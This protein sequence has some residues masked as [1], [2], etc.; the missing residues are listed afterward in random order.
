M[1]ATREANA[2]ALSRLEICTNR[3]TKIWRT[4]EVQ[5]L[6]PWC[7]ARCRLFC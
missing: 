6:A 5:I 1:H 3:E 2:A 4:D 7:S